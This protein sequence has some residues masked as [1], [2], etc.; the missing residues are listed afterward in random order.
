MG[1]SKLNDEIHT[2]DRIVSVNGQS[3]TTEADFEAAIADCAVGDVL[4]IEYARYSG[5]TS[6]TYTTTIT[7]QE[8]VP[9]SVNF[10]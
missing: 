1:S 4:T 3:I 7:I 10:S 2:F 9:D 8:Y 6:T 5:S